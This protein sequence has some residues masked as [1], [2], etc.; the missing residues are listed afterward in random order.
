MLSICDFPNV[1][2]LHPLLNGLKM[3]S[4]AGSS[5]LI[6]S[7]TVSSSFNIPTRFNTAITST[8]AVLGCLT[9]NAV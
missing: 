2:F 8:P 6:S 7:C 9:T 1:L 4:L 3:K 5:F